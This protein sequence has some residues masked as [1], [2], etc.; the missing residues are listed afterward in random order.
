MAAKAAMAELAGISNNKAIK[1]P[2]KANDPPHIEDQIITPRKLLACSVAINA[3]S[4]NKASNNNAP[5]IFMA[6]ATV[7]AVSKIIV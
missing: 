1:K 4:N 7:M 6:M 3:G 2:P 5:I